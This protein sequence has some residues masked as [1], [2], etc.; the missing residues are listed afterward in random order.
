MRPWRLAARK[1]V[2]NHGAAGKWARDAS[3]YEEKADDGSRAEGERAGCQWP[4]AHDLAGAIEGFGPPFANA[5]CRIRRDLDRIAAPA[6]RPCQ[7]VLADFLTLERTHVG[8][9]SLSPLQ[10]IAQRTSRSSG[11]S[12]A[13]G[14]RAAAPDLRALRCH[15]MVQGIKKDLRHHA[16]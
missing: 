6:R 10:S 13:F 1:G 15:S 2:A 5:F 4:R 12:P 9:Q 11:G 3:A 16:K 8:H 14:R 7:N